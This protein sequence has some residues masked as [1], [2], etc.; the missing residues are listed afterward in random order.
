MTVEH[1]NTAWR[2]RDPATT[3]WY[4][5]DGGI[6]LE[7]LRRY[8]RVGA[9]VIDVGGGRSS[10]GSLL[11]A[12]PVPV[13]LTVMDISGE[14]IEALRTDLGSAATRVRTVV[15]DATEWTPPCR[16]DVWHDRAVFHFLTEP[17]QRAGYI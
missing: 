6:S 10:L 9:A 2:D 17:D 3:S 5:P 16:Y 14:A 12:G 11:L 15:A 8:V 1:W 13:D 4:R 7:L